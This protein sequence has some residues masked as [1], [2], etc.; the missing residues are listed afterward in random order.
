[1]NDKGTAAGHTVDCAV[2][3]SPLV[4]SDEARTMSCSV[5]GHQ[6]QTLI[7]CPHGHFVCDACHEMSALEVL[8]EVI[9]TSRSTDPAEILERVM[10]HPKVCMHGPEHHVIVPAVIVAAYHDAD[11]GDQ[12]ARAEDV[13]RAVDRAQRLLGGWCGY[14]GV[15]GAAAGVGVAVSL[16]ADATPLTGPQR[17]LAMAATCAAQERML[18]D[19]PRCCKRASR[20][21][22]DAA[23]DFLRNRLGVELSTPAPVACGYSARN[24]QCAGARCPYHSPV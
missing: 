14:Y 5:C 7:W 4:Y 20:I 9:A 3:A 2:C 17:T 13:R 12:D 8:M 11:G 22:V 18:D 21:A 24:A 1:M 23:V 6:Q 15:C 16:I 10:A 19:D